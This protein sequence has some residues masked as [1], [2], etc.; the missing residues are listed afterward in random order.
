MTVQIT[1]ETNFEVMILILNSKK[2]YHFLN[3]KIDINIELLEK[4]M[5][6]HSS[7]LA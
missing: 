3:S 7:T 6:A 5:A 4:A 1:P 2:K